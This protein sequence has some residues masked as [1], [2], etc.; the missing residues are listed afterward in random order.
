MHFHGTNGISRVK[1]WVLHQIDRADQ[2]L[3]MDQDEWAYR[4][5]WTVK[6][7]GFGG[8]HYRNP[9]FDLQKAERI[10]AEVY[11]ESVSG[12]VAA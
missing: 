7:T 5:G 11:A 3:C 12:N 6:K 1:I 10:Y 2:E 4:L 9:L 8:R